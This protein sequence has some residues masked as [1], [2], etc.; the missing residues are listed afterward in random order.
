MKPLSCQLADKEPP[1]RWGEASQP[2]E[3]Y[4]CTVALTAY[5]LVLDV[6]DNSL[7]DVV[8]VAQLGWPATNC[9]PW[10]TMFL[11]AIAGSP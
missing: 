8:R 6:S 1:Q 2:L 10:A 11:V 3:S 9:T 7:L 4:N 5:N